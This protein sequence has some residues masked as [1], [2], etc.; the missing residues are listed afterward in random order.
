MDG[1]WVPVLNMEEG[2]A[3]STVL[4]TLF[5][6]CT[7]DGN[8]MAVRTGLANQDA[9]EFGTI[10]SHGDLWCGMFDY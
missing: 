8:A 9:A 3:M 6:Q 1:V 5:M 2:T 10:P 7:G 4:A